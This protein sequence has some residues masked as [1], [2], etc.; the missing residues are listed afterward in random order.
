M[1]DY[2]KRD[3]QKQ[4][5]NPTFKVELTEDQLNELIIEVK[6]NDKLVKFL[7]TQRERLLREIKKQKDEKEFKEKAELERRKNLETCYEIVLSHF[8][9]VDGL[10]GDFVVIG[11]PWCNGHLVELK[12]GL[13][14]MDNKNPPELKKVEANM[15]KINEY[16]KRFAPGTT[17]YACIDTFEH[18]KIIREISRNLECVKIYL[19]GYS[20]NDLGNLTFET[21]S[22]ELQKKLTERHDATK[23]VY[24]NLHN[25]L[26]F[27]ELQKY[28]P[29]QTK[30]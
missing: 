6:G 7:T 25:M 26:Y 9:Y 20:V 17:I 27:S 28:R 22:V 16:E 4:E 1:T 5:E 14:E 19:H 29:E 24:S 11:G 3:T 18:N 10:L 2:K 13:I 30:D 8:K 23:K 12:K 21:N 15:V